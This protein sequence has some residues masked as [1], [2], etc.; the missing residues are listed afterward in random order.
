V[1][2]GN[3]QNLQTPAH[4]RRSNKSF[5]AAA[6]RFCTSMIFC[7]FEVRNN[8]ILVRRR[9]PR[10]YLG[11]V[12]GG[13]FFKVQQSLFIAKKNGNQSKKSAILFDTRPIARMNES[14]THIPPLSFNVKA[15]KIR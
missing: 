4:M 5:R 7:I 3:N 11:A 10:P 13:K 9:W 2:E 15:I 12:I 6:S 1:I 14:K 8:K